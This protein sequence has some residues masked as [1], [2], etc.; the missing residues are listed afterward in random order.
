[1]TGVENVGVENVAPSS[2]AYSGFQ[3]RWPEVRK[4]GDGSPP[5][6]S[7]GKTRYRESEDGPKK[8]KPYY[9]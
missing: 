9:V 6:E 1:M 5:V 4:Y 8:F 2:G 7:R 3:V